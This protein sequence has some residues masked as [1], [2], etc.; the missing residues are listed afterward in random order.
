MTLLVLIITRGLCG[1]YWR[2]SASTYLASSGA[3]ID[4]GGR[5]RVLGPFFSIPLIALISLLP[6]L[7][8]FPGLILGDLSVLKVLRNLSFLFLGLL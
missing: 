4:A 6:L 5:G 1:V 2:R 8:V 7:F 3:C